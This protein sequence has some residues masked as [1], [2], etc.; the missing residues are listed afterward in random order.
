MDDRVSTYPGRVKLTPVA[1]LENTYQMEMADEPTQEGTPPTKANL[2][3]DTVAALWGGDS[4]SKVTD[5]LRYAAA[6]YGTCATAAATSAKV[7]TL[8]DFVLSIGA[9]IGVNFSYKNTASSPTLNVNGTGA[10]S[11]YFNGAI[12]GAAQVPKIA[13]LQYDGTYWQLINGPAVQ[14][15]TGNY[16]GTGT[17]GSGS[18]NSLSFPFAPAMVFVVANT[19]TMF[20]YVGNPMIL[21]KGRSAKFYITPGVTQTDITPTFSGNSVAWYSTSGPYSQQ[22]ESGQQ[23]T[24]VAIG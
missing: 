8:S 13:Y 3:T 17:Y 11:I 4:Y 20:N 9:V 5:I 2:L 23:Y 6:R 22:N 14:L 15:A 18:P 10:K 7:A 24:Y 21:V 19:S 12:V 1:G 16:T